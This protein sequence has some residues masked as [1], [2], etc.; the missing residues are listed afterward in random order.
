[1]FERIEID[2]R[3]CGGSP[4]IRGTRIPVAVIIDQ[5]ANGESWDA[6]LQGYPELTADD[7]RAALLFAKASIENSEIIPA[8]I[9]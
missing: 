2:P 5:L 3:R 9:G 4:V 8:P 7:I 6:L 1:M